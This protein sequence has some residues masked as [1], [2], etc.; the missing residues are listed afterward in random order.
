[1]NR[2]RWSESAIRH[3]VEEI[4]KRR[5]PDGVWQYFVNRRDVGEVRQGLEK[6]AWLAGEI[7]KLL[8]ATDPSSKAG[9]M[10]PPAETPRR[11]RRGKV[12]LARNDAVSEF[13][14]ERARND[15]G[16]VGFRK[17]FLS[18]AVLSPSN[19]EAWINEQGSEYTHA[20]VVR[21][22][23]D[24]QITPGP[25]G[26]HL[27]L[28]LTSVKPEQVEGMLPVDF[29]A[30]QR[31]QCKWVHRRPI[32][33]DGPLRTLLLLSRRLAK[34][35]GWTEDQATMFVLTDVTPEIATARWGVL[36]VIPLACLTGISQ[37]IG[38]Q[39]TPE[40][41]AKKYR[42]IR[43]KILGPKRRGL[44]EKH[45]RLAVFALKHQNLNHDALR[46]WNN[47]YPTWSYRKVN[48][49]AKEARQAKKR[50]EEWLE[51]RPFNPVK[52][53]QYIESPESTVKPACGSSAKPN[54]GPG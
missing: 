3:K 34:T 42:K 18:G 47:Q 32:G 29:I 49:F 24:T 50:Q 44:G 52:L 1:M 12:L 38:L 48:R 46:D 16:V 51:Q 37:T 25:D 41:L 13:I 15:V 36:P 33:R 39:V 10:L 14:A 54:S 2:Y 31:P 4:M 19:V 23:R 9:A 26:L 43:S 11:Q 8:S 30:Y 53:F 20:A 7:E 40:D 45:C 21:I 17:R 35:F 27:I 6:P 5:T 22:P 28:K